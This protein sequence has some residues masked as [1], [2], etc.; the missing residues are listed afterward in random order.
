[1][2]LLV[3]NGPVLVIDDDPSLVTF[4]KDY[5][6][7][8]GCEVYSAKNGQDALNL[9]D[10]LPPAFIILDLMMPFLDGYETCK[11]IRKTSQVPILMLTAKIEEE[12][13]L[14]GLYMGADD[15]LTKPFS[16]RELVARMQT[17]LRRCLNKTDFFTKL[18]CGYF[19]YHEEKH[20]FFWKSSPIH[21]TYQEAQIAIYL[22]ESKGKVCTREQLLNC[23]YPNG[24]SDVVDRIVDVH[25]GNIRQKI[26]AVDSSFNLIRTIRGIGYCLEVPNENEAFI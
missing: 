21:L 3:L 16:P 18:S 20:K 9:I 19:F 24:D 10:K 25:I 7:A 6:E 11:K 8:L 2:N 12:D 14:R 22:L 26:R 15:Y 4:L 5:L 17:I 23:L 1:M 13:K